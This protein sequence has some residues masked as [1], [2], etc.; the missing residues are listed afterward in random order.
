[1]TTNLEDFPKM[2]QEDVKLDEATGELYL[3]GVT[4]RMR[5]GQV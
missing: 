4:G 1:M 2:F 3:Q 5:V